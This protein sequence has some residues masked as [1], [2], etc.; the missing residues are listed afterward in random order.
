MTDKVAE[1]EKALE[2]EKQEYIKSQKFLFFFKV[3]E[4]DAL[5][6]WENVHECSFPAYMLSENYFTL[7]RRKKYL[8]TVIQIQRDCNILHFKHAPCKVELTDHE[9]WLLTLWM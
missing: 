8:D 6:T 1:S 9:F 4:K 5:H 7:E 2:E 3:S